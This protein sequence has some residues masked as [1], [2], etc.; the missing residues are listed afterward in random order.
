M[1]NS[2][3]QQFGSLRAMRIST[4]GEFA[5][6]R[7]VPAQP[8]TAHAPR[9]E[10]VAQE[11]WRSRG[12]A[13]TLLKVLLCRTRRRASREELLEALWP[14]E[15]E[16]ID[17]A[18]AF[19][20]AVSVLRKVLCTQ[21]GESLLA[22]SRAGGV[23]IFSL[24]GQER[25]W[26]DADAFLGSVEQATHAERM[27]ADP[28]P[29]LEAAHALVTGEFLEDE[30]Y[31]GWAEPRRQMI[32]AAHHRCL[33]RL[34]DLYLERNRPEQAETVL[35]LF[36]I[37]EPTDEDVLCRLLLLL[38]EQGRSQEAWQLYEHTARVLDQEFHTAPMPRTSMLAERLRSIITSRN[39][40]MQVPAHPRRMAETQRTLPVEAGL[41]LSSS[42][43][44]TRFAPSP[45]NT[46]DMATSR[47]Q[48][49]QAMLS[50]ASAALVL[51]PREVLSPDAWE[52]LAL[53][54]RKPSSVDASA[55]QDL[56]TITKSY[57]RL[58]ANTTSFDLMNGVLGHFETVLGMLQHPQPTATLR[59][60]CSI[61]GETAQILGQMLFD[62]HDFSAAWSYYTI[63]LHAAQEALNTD[64]RAVGLGRMSFL[65]TYSEQAREALPLLE[66]A[67]SLAGQ[68]ALPSIRSWLAAVEAEAQARNS[69]SAACISALDQAELL[70]MRDGFEAD[71]YA[72]GLNPSRLAGYKGVCFVRLQQ[73]E[74]ALP[75][76]EEAL[77]L[78][79][80]SALR[81]QSTLLTDMAA[82]LLQQ[83]AIEQACDLA[84]R[85]LVIT[86]E[87]RSRSV[88]QRLRHLRQKLE[89]WN[90]TSAVR[91]VDEQLTALSVSLSS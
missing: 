63:A 8:S 14:Q 74:M 50:I 51:P 40:A 41:S 79:P 82:A 62:L 66:E 34:A 37:D 7:L 2:A 25:L 90:T 58:R 86:R 12:P 83:G 22:K 38:Q 54:S 9:Y 56:E 15:E 48:V 36:L 78:L 30:L 45:L 67:Q 23:T 26:V 70:A 88:L 53:V 16:E 19:D 76:L 3:Q 65:L 52:R 84:V 24:P 21:H 75:A 64:L 61:A 31:S 11:E 59:R 44:S 89:P 46:L 10:R 32:N 18:H 1:G 20:S 81:R 27:G 57:W 33:Y 73:P 69:D 39:T 91:D 87:T 35:H 85:A 60:L 77:A 6:E 68:S 28:L 17:V 55:L 42:P 80:P 29:I 43:F 4:F 47:R 71:P 5:L 72:T 13:K 49:L